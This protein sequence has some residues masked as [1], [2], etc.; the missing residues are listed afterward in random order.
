MLEPQFYPELVARAL[1][2]DEEPFAAMVDDDNPW[3][4]GLALTAVVGVTVGIAQAL[5][6]WLTRGQ[7]ARPG[8]RAKAPESQD[9][10]NS[11]PSLRCRP[12]PSTR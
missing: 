8:K 10:A 6:A 3:V 5:G 11:Q 1:V 2:L 12:P 9:G 4:E 7:F